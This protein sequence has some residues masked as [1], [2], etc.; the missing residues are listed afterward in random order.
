MY[1]YIYKTT[2]LVNGRVYIGQH[3]ARR[4]C[5]SYRGGGSRLHRAI[6]KFGKHNFVVEMLVKA[7]NQFE[8]DEFER[9]MI[10]MHRDLDIYNIQSGGIDGSWGRGH[11]RKNCTCVYCRVLRGEIRGDN[12]WWYGRDTHG[13]NNTMFGRQHSEATLRK[14]SECKRGRKNPMFGVHRFGKNAPSYGFKWSA[15]SKR[16]QS[17][18]FKG[19]KQSPERVW[20]RLHVLFHRGKKK[21]NKECPFCQGKIKLTDKIRGYLN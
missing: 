6:K 17:E 3:R 4:F 12:H 2:N 19:R 1:G 8:L 16:K 13:K 11:H 20:K 10:F 15:S 9:L 7:E 14:Q 18:T 5:P 21:K